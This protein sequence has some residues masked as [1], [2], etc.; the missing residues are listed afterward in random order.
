[1]RA[2]EWQAP[3]RVRLVER[4]EPTPESGQAVV[5]V[6]NCGIC[7]S[8]LHSFFHG[9]AA[10][11]GQVLGHEFSGRVVS[12]P[13]VDG[14]APGDRVTVRPLIPCGSCAVCLAG[15]P[16]R[17]ERSLD[18][19]Y[20]VSGA[21]AER[22]LVPRAVAGETVFRLPDTVDDRAGA[23][24]EPLAVGMHAIVRGEADPGQVIVV[25]GAGMIGLGV[26]A[27][28]RSRGCERILAVD[29][30]ELRRERAV[31]VGAVAAVDPA[32]EDVVSVARGFASR[33]GGPDR[34]GVD[35]VFDCAGA[36]KALESG[37]RALKRG[38]RV[39]LVAA[40]GREA[41][42]YL[43]RVIGKEI[44][45]IGSIGY[46]DEFPQVVSLLAEGRLDPDLFVSHTFPLS[47]IEEA[48]RTQ[49]DVNRAL[50]VL[51]QPADHR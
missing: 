42:V 8:D 27:L 17:C 22:V 30:S 43:D 23:L 13:E 5:D 33:F 44:S 20:G 28:L 37:L 21:F 1:M 16:Q 48:F 26:I 15:E 24:V 12:A 39:V 45:L 4:D 29:L 14:I 11:P 6:F 32:L 40:Y 50:K 35:L 3:E 9:V 41:P 46:R 18:I 38:G 7:G 10:K 51:V 47:D 34:R 2:V 49:A 19:G 36:A 25:L 31:A